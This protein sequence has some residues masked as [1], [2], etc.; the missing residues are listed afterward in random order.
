M[1]PLRWR[2]NI[3][4]YRSTKLL[5]KREREILRHVINGETNKTISD[6]L[7]ISESTVKK[8]VYNIFLKFN[9]KNRNE[10]I[11]KFT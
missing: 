6:K 9:V 5:S 2:M 1:N 11:R 3:A 8:H 7:Y 4:M 10:L